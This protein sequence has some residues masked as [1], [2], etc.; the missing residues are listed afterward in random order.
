MPS[1]PIAAH[2]GGVSRQADLSDSDE[3][4]TLPPAL[5]GIDV[6]LVAGSP[7]CQPFSRAGSSKIRSLIEQG[8]RSEEDE[9]RDLWQGFLRVVTSARSIGCADGE[10]P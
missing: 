8:V 2:F 9:R 4:S 1:R 7:P 5:E 3:I 10:R 6:S